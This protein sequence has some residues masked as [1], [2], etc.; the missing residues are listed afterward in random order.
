[1]NNNL[2]RT[3]VCTYIPGNKKVQWHRWREL[4]MHDLQPQR[5]QNDDHHH[6][7]NNK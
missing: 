5:T 4:W 2:N 6:P 3:R 1:M 7:S